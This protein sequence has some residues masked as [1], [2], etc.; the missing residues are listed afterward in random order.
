MS[1][2][3]KKYQESI[4][5]EEK[6]IKPITKPKKILSMFPQ[7]ISDKSKKDEFSEMTISQDDLWFLYKIKTGKGTRM[8]KKE[9]LPKFMAV[10]EREVQK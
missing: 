6:R 10:F 9:L 3:L 8:K 4:K 2:L 7:K 5:M 1:E